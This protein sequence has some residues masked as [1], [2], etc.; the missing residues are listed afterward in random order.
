MK[1][2][3]AFRRI[4]R[5]KRVERRLLRVWTD[6]QAAKRAC[7]RGRARADLAP[8]F[9]LRQR[10]LH[11]AQ[12]LVQHAT[13]DV[14][15]ARWARLEDDLAKAPHADAALAAHDAFLDAVLRDL[16]LANHALLGLVADLERACDRFADAA[17]RFHDAALDSVPLGAR[18]R[19]GVQATTL[20]AGLADYVAAVRDHDAAWRSLMAT[21]LDA[22]RSECHLQRASHLSDLLARLQDHRVQFNF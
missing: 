18:S 14:V 4:F 9:L 1:Y 11:F 8:A 19:A 6:Q 17:D 16:L 2:Q 13:C 20:T 7:G 10:M 12:S 5:A 21:F 22:L 3:L 15:G